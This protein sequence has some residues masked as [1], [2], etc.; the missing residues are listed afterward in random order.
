MSALLLLLLV[1]T[2]GSAER[3]YISTAAG[4]GTGGSSGD[5]GAATSANLIFPYDMCIDNSNGDIYIAGTKEQRIRKVAVS[6]GI[7]S[8]IAGKGGY[9]GFSGDGGQGTSAL[10]N[11]PY[12][13]ALDSNGNVFIADA[14]NNRVRKV[15][16]STGIITAFAGGGS[17]QVNGGDATSANLVCPMAV[18][19]DSLDNVYIADRDNNKIKK[20]TSAGIIS[21]VVGTGTAGSSGNGG[22]ATSAQITQP[23]GVSVDSNGNIFVS[24][25]FYHRVRKVTAATGIITMFA[26]TGV[27]G[28]FEDKCTYT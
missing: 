11:E 25:H 2:P 14:F 5:A 13:V 16:V 23:R 22:A 17:S 12:G 24:E 28:K 27:Q 9:S 7:I 6:S 20:V 26:G 8:S 3:Y 18:A 19:V 4:T 21:T 10:L 15:T 1:Y